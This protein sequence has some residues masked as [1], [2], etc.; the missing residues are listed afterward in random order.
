MP[1]SAT[2]APDDLP[3]QLVADLHLH[4][5]TKPQLLKGIASPWQ[6]VDESPAELRRLR[7]AR[8]TRGDFAK[9]H[10]S[11][12]RLIG[13]C[14]IVPERYVYSKLIT[15][16]GVLARFFG[17]DVAKLRE[18]L[19]TKPFTL[20]QRELKYLKQHATD[21]ATGREAVIVRNWN[22][23]AETL[24]NPQKIAITLGI[25]G[26]HNLG[27]E[28]TGPDFPV[29]GKLYNFRN[30]VEEPEEAT[31]DL[32][33]ERIRWMQR[34][35]VWYLTLNHFVYN[36]LA[37]MP[38]AA[39]LRGWKKIGHNPFRSIEIAGQYR[40]LTHLGHH[41]VEGCLLAGITLDLKHA[42]ALTRAQV[43]RLAAKYGRPVI[44]SHVG[45]S[46][47]DTN[48][49]HNRLINLE[50]E[51][52]DRV[53]SREKLNPWD[54]N[55]HDDDL[56]RIHELGGL[57]GLILDERV[58]ASGYTQQVVAKTEDWVLPLWHQLEHAWQV[59]RKAGVPATEALDSLCMGSDYDGFIE[60]IGC[61]VSARDWRTGTGHTAPITLHDA[62]LEKLRKHPKAF[63]G[64]KLEPEQILQKVFR[65]NY[66][67]FCQRWYDR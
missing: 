23:L 14:L 57:M 15:S 24:A 63:A 39:E 27:F 18:L 51:P 35:H 53:K 36:H 31:H 49:R 33:E 11:D 50:D 4:P 28:Y 16:P 9:L 40:G 22:H 7:N 66:L 1:A 43:Y 59:L 2:T 34:E 64:S 54:I 48:V 55:L 20:L 38:K 42:D 45:F 56:V 8:I 65:D 6:D 12:I 3:Q 67:R 41:L 25:E 52:N 10:D 30:R 13:A 29:P 44:A 21:P 47:R 17:M 46:G 58:L 5:T 26:A 37:S 19:C 61:A 62:L 32:V 60:P